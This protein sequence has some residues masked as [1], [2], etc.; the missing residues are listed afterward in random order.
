MAVTW[1]FAL[2]TRLEMTPEVMHIAVGYLDGELA[3]RTIPFEEPP[4]VTATCFSMATKFPERSIRLIADLA[5][6]CRNQYDR[7]AFLRCERQITVDLK[8]RLSLSTAPLFLVRFLDSIQ[9][10]E[11][12]VWVANFFCDLSL[13]PIE[14]VGF[15]QDIMALA[16]VC[17][18]KLT[19]GEVGTVSILMMNGHIT[20]LEPTW[21]CAML[22][23]AHAA[24]IQNQ[25]S[26]I[27]F[28]RCSGGRQSELVAQ[29]NLGQ[30]ILTRLQL[31]M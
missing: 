28:Q 13:L 17:L 9:A 5:R 19:L 24:Q 31:E 3:Q 11:D 25:P 1:I 30:D 7:E 14:L 10:G 12:I 18:A 2:Q 29:L 20:E 4:L 22:L 6:E 15:P 8:P 16:S 21:Q 27:L 23:L 26:H